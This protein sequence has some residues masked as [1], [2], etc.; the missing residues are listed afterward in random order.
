MS[1]H[2][3]TTTCRDTDSKEI[4]SPP[5]GRHQALSLFM[6]LQGQGYL[7]YMV[8]EN[9]GQYRVSHNEFQA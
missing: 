6:R 7:P 2:H 9:T 4:S 3:N 1:K 8:E 5:L